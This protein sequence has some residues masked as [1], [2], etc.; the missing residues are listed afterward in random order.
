MNI[1]DVVCGKCSGH[2]FK[3]VDGEYK[4][5]DCG[6][7]LTD[8]EIQK[9]LTM[10]HE[11]YNVNCMATGARKYKSTVLADNPGFYVGEQ[12][13]TDM[14]T[15]IQIPKTGVDEDLAKEIADTWNKIHK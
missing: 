11:D 3:S 8:D 14:L 9:L 6:Y 7:V 1:Y 5:Q 15:V 2:N 12:I 4:C 10:A 13:D